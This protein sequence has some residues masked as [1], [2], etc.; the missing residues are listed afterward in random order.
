MSKMIRIQRLKEPKKN[1]GVEI[2]P[3][4]MAKVQGLVIKNTNK[5]PVYAGTWERKPWN[6]AKKSKAKK[7]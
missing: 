3:G 7:K 5:F 2:L 4:K 1:S 6:K